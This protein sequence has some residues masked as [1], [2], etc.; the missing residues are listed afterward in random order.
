MHTPNLEMQKIQSQIAT[1]LYFTYNADQSKICEHTFKI[2][3][4]IN[5]ILSRSPTIV[6]PFI[7][8]STGQKHL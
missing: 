3:I 8:R 1:N 2:Q 7:S 5:W 6:Q 4:E